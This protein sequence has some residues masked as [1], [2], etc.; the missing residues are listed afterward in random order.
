MLKV[1]TFVVLFTSASWIFVLQ[2]CRTTTD[3]LGKLLDYI[4]AR[5][6]NAFD[7]FCETLLECD[8]SHV[9]EFLKSVEGRYT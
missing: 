2:A 8:H 9:A 7:R 3:Q 6:P 4:P 1:K 5:G